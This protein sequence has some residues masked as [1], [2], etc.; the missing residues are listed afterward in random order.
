MKKP[1]NF[2]TWD[3]QGKP[4]SQFHKKPFSKCFNICEVQK[5]K[6]ASIKIVSKK[7]EMINTMSNQ[8]ILSELKDKQLPVYGTN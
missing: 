3:D 4:T 7:E 6:D 8:Q 5:W 2:T 1:S